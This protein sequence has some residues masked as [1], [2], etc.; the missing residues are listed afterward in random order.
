[1]LSNSPFGG[2]RHHLMLTPRLFGSSDSWL[3]RASTVPVAQTVWESIDTRI[4]LRCICPLSKRVDAEEIFQESWC[5]IYTS[6]SQPGEL[7]HSLLLGKQDGKG[8]EKVLLP[9]GAGNW[10]T[11]GSSENMDDRRLGWDFLDCLHAHTPLKRT[12][13]CTF[14][15]RLAH[16]PLTQVKEIAGVHKYPTVLGQNSFRK[17]LPMF[18]CNRKKWM[19]NYR[20][21]P[22]C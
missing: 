19:R 18:C 15:I 17:I 14:E 4:D 16:K 12:R 9:E 13:I 6:W 10:K 2:P 11:P 5:L 21:D 20:R 7:I 8:N 3:S 1:M 22:F